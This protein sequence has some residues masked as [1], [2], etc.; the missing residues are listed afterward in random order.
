MARRSPVTLRALLAGTACATVAV[1][2]A[3]SAAP[4]VPAVAVA[5]PEA[6]TAGFTSRLVVALQGQP[7]TFVNGDVS[8]HTLTSKQTKP[9]RV[10]FGSKYYVIRVPLFDSS[11]V[12][13][14][15]SRDVK[16]VT[17]LKPG[18]YDFYCS[19]HTGMTGQ[20]VVEPAG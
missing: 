17:A 1:T 9:Q 14:G 5:G 13:P 11:G 18:K 8:G 19:L 3:A 12:N 2:T 16:G 20:L 15:A 10:R 7:L 6:A 4:P